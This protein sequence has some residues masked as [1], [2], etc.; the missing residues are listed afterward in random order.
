MQELYYLAT[1]MCISQCQVW[2]CQPRNL[3]VHRVILKLHGY[4]PIGIHWLACMLAHEDKLAAFSSGPA[5]STWS[6]CKARPEVTPLLWGFPASS[7]GIGQQPH[8]PWDVAAVHLGLG[9]GS[10]P[11]GTV[12]I[13]F[14]GMAKF[15]WI[16]S[17]V[18]RILILSDLV[19]WIAGVSKLVKRYLTLFIWRK[20]PAR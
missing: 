12:P 19:W 1:G 7:P 4:F 9:P 14:R 13:P 10:W 18:L 16:Q 11:L 5:E 6:S 20:P 2:I 3:V 15:S 17:S 8:V